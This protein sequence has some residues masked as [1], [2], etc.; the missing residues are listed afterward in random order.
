MNLYANQIGEYGFAQKAEDDLLQMSQLSNNGSLN[1]NPDTLSFNTVL[2]AWKN[3]AGGIKNAKRAESI[4]RL[5]VK[6]YSEGHENVRPD[7]ISWYTVIYAY[8]KHFKR[9]N[10]Y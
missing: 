5:M 3:S 10:N 4:L 7:S 8:G 9:H 1:I 6:L 2:K